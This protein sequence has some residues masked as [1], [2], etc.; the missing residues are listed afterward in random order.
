M[1]RK[2][3][4]TL[5]LAIGSLTFAVFLL[6]QSLNSP[7]ASAP[8]MAQVRVV[9]AASDAPAVDVRVNGILLPVLSGIAFK[10]V[11]DYASVMSGTFTVTV[12]PAGSP[13]PVF[14]KT[15]TVMSGID[16]TAVAY[17]TLAEADP[18]PFDILVATDDNSVPPV[19]KARARFFHLVPGAPDV[20]IAIQGGPDL[21]TG[22]TY[23]Q[24]SPYVEIDADTYDLELQLEGLPLT[25]PVPA[26]TADPNSIYSF[27]AVGT[28]ASPDIVQAL[29]KQYVRVRAFHGVS[30]APPVDVWVDGGKAFSSVAYKDLTD[31][32]AVMSGTYTLGLAPAG[33][34]MPILTR[35]LVLT[36]GMDFTVAAAGTLTV[37][38]MYTAELVSYMDD[39]S[40]PLPGKAHVRFIHL[41]PDAPLPVNIGVTGVVTPIFSNVTYK[42]A[43]PYVP[44]D[45]GHYD[46]EAYLMGAPMMP[47]ATVSDTLFIDGVV[48]TGFGVGLAAG[49]APVEVV[50]EPMYKIFMPIVFKNF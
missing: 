17:G 20:D 44:V 13:D 45:A 38:D 29:D 37:T 30:D 43:T 34:E 1:K 16:Y 49:P 36:G 40:P 39:N 15:L 4:I 3:L 26:V 6:G 18:F 28:A 12:A 42:Q 9:H 46:L 21:L 8:L 48:Y 7:V 33:I 2:L 32:A 22:V 24:A 35:T 19:G 25:I 14:T 27:F 10:D 50:I 41:V 47:I 11:T 5:A 31:Y 23:G